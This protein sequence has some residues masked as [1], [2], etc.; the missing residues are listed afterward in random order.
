MKHILIAVIIL[1]SADSCSDKKDRSSWN[2]IFNQKVSNSIFCAGFGDI[3]KG[4]MAGHGGQCYFTVDGGKK[5]TS[6]VNLSACRFG[7]DMQDD[8]SSAWNCGNDGH[9]RYSADGGRQWKEVES[10]SG[11]RTPE[12]CKFISFCTESE[13]WTAKHGMLGATADGAK[14]W[15]EIKLPDGINEIGAVFLEKSGTGYIYDSKKN[16]LFMTKN[17]GETWMGIEMPEAAFSVPSDTAAMS[18]LSVNGDRIV[19]VTNKIKK[20][21]SRI[22]VFRSEDGGKAWIEEPLADK[23]GYLY[24]NKSGSCITLLTLSSELML[25]S[26]AAK[27]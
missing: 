12:H 26:R 25:Y 3:E 10:F 17:S 24:I 23:A 19:F 5:W 1:F 13:G 2:N 8:L 16:M 4:I 6:A 9:I 27:I 11:G 21:D 14:T 22:S 18:A 15:K 7:L 20:T